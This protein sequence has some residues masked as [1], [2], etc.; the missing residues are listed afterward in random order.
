[1]TMAGVADL[2]VAVAMGEHSAQELLSTAL[3]TTLKNR[4]KRQHQSPQPLTRQPPQE[5]LKSEDGA[6]EGVMEELRKAVA[7][8]LQQAQQQQQQEEEEEEE[9][10][11]QQ[12]EE[13][14]EEAEEEVVQRQE[15]QSP[16]KEEQEQ[17]DDAVG[18]QMTETLLLPLLARVHAVVEHEVFGAAVDSITDTDSDS[19]STDDND[20]SNDTNDTTHQDGTAEAVAALRS[21]LDC[22]LC[23]ALLCA[24]ATLPCGHTLCR[25]CVWRTLDH[26]FET[27]PL[28]PL[29]RADLSPLLIYLNKAARRESQQVAMTGVGESAT[30]AVAGVAGGAAFSHGAAQIQPT[31]VLTQFLRRHFPSAV[32]ARQAQALEE[33]ALATID[34]GNDGQQTIAAVSATNPPVGEGDVER[35]QTSVAESGGTAGSATL[36][37]HVRTDPD[38]SSGTAAASSGS[39]GGGSSGG[40]ATSASPSSPSSPSSSSCWLALFVCSL[41]YP[42]LRSPLHIFEPRYRLMMRRAIQSGQKRFGMVL[43]KP[44]RE[45]A[46]S[47]AGASVPC[48]CMCVPMCQLLR[49]QRRMHGESVT[50]S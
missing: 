12:Q 36:T 4:Q 49:V 14:A 42:R 27:V 47:V 41:A 19:D 30:T 5:Q 44:E 2:V 18:A 20:S 29:C 10:E 35:G 24:P 26:A 21:E 1:M 17:E 8:T 7:A 9:Q 34:N 28:C 40:S 50:Q 23:C 15:T 6:E 37:G 3:L 31:Q 11:Q 32:V 38:A 48:A 46:E 43:P 16:E 25:A 33:E 45:E 13:K 39:S 22:C